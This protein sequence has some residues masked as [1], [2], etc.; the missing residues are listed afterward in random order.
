MGKNFELTECELLTMKCI[1]DAEEPITCSEIVVEM[2][3]RFHLNYK[4]TTVYTFL[5]KLM[6]KGFVKSYR[7]GVN[8]YS[9]ARDR[10]DYRNGQLTFMKDFWFNGSSSDVVA[11]FCKNENMTA[12]DLD[13]IKRMINEDNN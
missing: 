10:D 4:D 6:D 2:N 7:R 11:A 9:P 5:K 1:W 3:E 8:F 12:K 13:K